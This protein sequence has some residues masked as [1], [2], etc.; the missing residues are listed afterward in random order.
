[1]VE[2]EVIAGE[3][4]RLGK[5]HDAQGGGDGALSG[6]E[7]DAD[8]E[9]QQP[10]ECRGG[11]QLTEGPHEHGDDRRRRLRR[12][13]IERSGAMSRHRMVGILSRAIVIG[14]SRR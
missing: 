3:V 7:H 4:F 5:P 8:E 14:V 13:R 1:V 12:G 6:R 10:I 2:H 9:W 11:E